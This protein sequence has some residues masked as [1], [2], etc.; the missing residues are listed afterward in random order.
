M[1]ALPSIAAAPGMITT[2]PVDRLAAKCALALAAPGPIPRVRIGK[3]PLELALLKLELEARL[4]AAAQTLRIFRP[5]LHATLGQVP[6]PCE[7]CKESLAPITIWLANANERPLDSRWQLER[8]WRAM[9]KTA[10]GLASTALEVLDRSRWAGVPLY[11]PSLAM[12]FAQWT[13]WWG[14]EDERAVLEEIRANEETDDTEDEKPPSDEELCETNNLVTKARIDRALPPEVT[15]PKRALKLSDLERLARGRGP[16]RELAARTLALWHAVTARK[17]QKS[18]YALHTQEDE[19][20]SLGFAA[21]LRWNARDPMYRIFDDHAQ[22]ICESSEA[23]EEAWGWFV[24]PSA[25]ELRDFFAHLEE[26]LALA[27]RQEE[28]LEALAERSRE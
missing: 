15:T 4:F 22:H 14:E 9:E 12:G 11:T 5:R 13:Y 8:R 26:R 27:R 16:G 6:A 23:L 20:W 17:R 1:I 18:K 28:L 19:T 3:L 21:A 7:C 10:P 2:A 25:A 24:V